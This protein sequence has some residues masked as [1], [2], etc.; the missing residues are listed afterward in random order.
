MGQQRNTS[1]S[2]SLP[3][4]IFKLDR[5]GIAIH[6]T[7]DNL[8]ARCV[9]LPP[10]ERALALEDSADLERAYASAAQQGDSAVPE[11]AEDEVD[12]HY[13]AFV[14]SNSNGRLY[15][16]DGDKKGPIDTGITLDP[17][18]DMISEKALDPVKRYLRQEKG[19]S[20]GFSLMALVESDAI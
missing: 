10:F 15:E 11:S 9:P 6:S 16:M 19:E 1:V 20:L 14:Q 5:D 7:L 8:N 18:E 2:C 13:I 12:Y 3:P 17:G 4:L